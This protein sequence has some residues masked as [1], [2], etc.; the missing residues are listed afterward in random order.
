MLVFVLSILSIVLNLFSYY[1]ISV[2]LA[3]ITLIIGIVKRK[4]KWFKY[5]IIISIIS[6][7]L[8]I[9]IFCYDCVVAA[10][11]LDRTNVW[12]NAIN[13]CY[14]NNE[15]YKECSKK[16]NECFDKYEQLDEAKQCADNLK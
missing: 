4:E 7:I 10:R 6:I 12:Q 3:I 13:E 2:P 1:I 11:I 5:A 9:G 15:N 8:G 16:V 14:T